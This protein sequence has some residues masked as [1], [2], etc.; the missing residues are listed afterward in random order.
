M[1]TLKS[2]PELLA[3]F[4]KL[5]KTM[6]VP[7]KWDGLFVIFGN[8]MVLKGEER[9]VIFNFET[10]R[11]GT[12][13][14][15]VTIKEQDIRSIGTN[16]V[17][18]NA[19]NMILYAFGKW[20][21][22]K[23]VK[24]DKDFEQLNALFTGVL[25][26]LHVEPDYTAEH[27]YFYK[28]GL[29]IT[30]EEVVMLA[31]ESYKQEENESDVSGGESGLW[32]S[33]VWQMCRYSFVLK[34]TTLAERKG[35]RLGNNFY[36]AGYLCPK[37]GRKLYMVVFPPEKEPV[38][39]TQEGRVRLARACTCAE[40]GIFYTPRPDRLILEGDVYVLDFEGDKAAYE[41]YREL[42]GRTGTREGNSNFNEYA[43]GRRQVQEADGRPDLNG[44][45]KGEMALRPNLSGIEKFDEAPEDEK[46]DGK[47]GGGEYEEAGALYGDVQEEY[48]EL[49]ELVEEGFYP[50]SSIVD[51]EQT[52]EELWE[53]RRS[54]GKKQKDKEERLKEKQE[55]DTAAVHEDAGSFVKDDDRNA[56]RQ[57]GGRDGDVQGKT[58]DTAGSGTNERQYEKRIDQFEK[59]SDRQIADLKKQIG[60]DSRLSDRDKKGFLEQL[61]MK[62]QKKRL[63]ELTKK[64]DAQSGKNYAALERF[65]E[66]I[67]KADIPAEE[68]ERLLSRVRTAKKEQGTKEAAELVA[69]MPSSLDRKG[70]E[71]YMNRL[72]NYREADISGYEEELG[73]KKRQAE[74]REAEDMVRRARKS[75]R[76]DL[77]ELQKRLREQ[78]FSPEI[79]SEYL[80][81]VK[82]AM[83]KMDRKRLDGA[84]ADYM[85]MTGEELDRLYRDIEEE[86]FLPE[87]KE[88]TL[89]KIGRRLQKIKTD[90]CELLIGK[91]KK[92]LSDAGVSDNKRHYFY[93][94]KR[95]LLKEVGEEETALIDYARGTYAA[96]AGPFE[97]PLLMVDTTRGNTGKEGMILTP[98]RL[99]YSNFLTCQ[100]IDVGD[101]K[102]VE[103]ATGLIGRGVYV[104]LENK[105]K[106]KIPYAVENKEL[107]NY[108]QALERFITYLKERPFS[109]REKY[110]VKEKH[111]TICCFRCGYVYKDMK[112][113]PKCGYKRNV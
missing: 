43:D 12:N 46:F 6:T 21:M 79:T 52:I 34:Q 58:A 19:L 63:S 35:K 109:R 38:I 49:L 8:V 27:Y 66:E 10:K 97:Y 105:T 39:D 107:K 69:K 15:D 2:T 92:E 36:L 11:V 83:E 26:E 99:Y 48:G 68:K 95:V 73:R 71:S 91:L 1:V 94:A 25:R 50:D 110:L 93:P 65:E 67:V 24:V 5:I 28:E 84:C 59:L 17:L 74:K 4:D 100:S 82:E 22:L 72:K 56:G 29:R 57:S 86:N 88:D 102:S 54:A 30:Y 112:E 104:Y 87:L 40:C 103:A 90:E 31:L 9:S 37:C 70:Y 23:R 98:E 16:T 111:E 106:Y 62:E 77:E 33:M 60:Q 42:I 7:V 113:C 20:G 45:E 78:A 32:H 89:G 101:I 3:V 13:I 47:H 81:R 18:V 75:T 51:M 64:A 108:A 44:I 85:N 96:Q 41:D 55:E 80:D 61:H 53:K 14:L 76:G